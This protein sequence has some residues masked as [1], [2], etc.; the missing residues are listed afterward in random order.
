MTGSQIPGAASYFEL[1][2]MWKENVRC[3]RLV[4][5]GMIPQLDSTN[6]VIARCIRQHFGVAL[7]N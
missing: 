7:A 3:V 5:C 4:V 6:R 2:V 1:I